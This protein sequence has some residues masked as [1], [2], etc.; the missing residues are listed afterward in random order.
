M[1]YSSDNGGSYSSGAVGNAAADIVVSA[2]KVQIAGGESVDNR[3][4]TYTV[5][6]TTTVTIAPSANGS[7]TITVRTADNKVD[8]YTVNPQTGQMVRN[9]VAANFAS[10]RR[11]SVP[12]QPN[13]IIP[14]RVAQRLPQPTLPTSDTNS[15]ETANGGAGGGGSLAKNGSADE[16]GFEGEVSSLDQYAEN[17][18]A[19]ALYKPGT[20][21]L[22]R[23]MMD[24]KSAVKTL[25]AFNSV[26]QKASLNKTETLPE[27]IVSATVDQNMA[28]L[29]VGQGKYSQAEQL[30]AHAISVMQ[31]YPQAPEYKILIETYANY[32]SKRGRDLE[33]DQYRRQILVADVVTNNFEVAK[34]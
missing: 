2:A 15:P 32:L 12:A 31:N 33:A 5:N 4:G 16:D 24:A 18:E 7:E 21:S 13:S 30:Y 23:Q 25:N 28:T 3:P 29:M 27:A 14:A 10:S 22:E 9:N 20:Q 8:T 19:D 26:L 34:V 17:A 1:T 11:P 6:G